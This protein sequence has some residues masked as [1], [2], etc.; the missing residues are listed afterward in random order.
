MRRGAI[1]GVKGRV[2]IQGLRLVSQASSGGGRAGAGGRGAGAAD[3]VGPASFRQLSDQASKYL[4]EAAKQQ[5]RRQGGAMEARGGEVGEGERLRKNL[6]E[7]F[8]DDVARGGPLAELRDAETVLC[9]VEKLKTGECSGMA[10]APPQQQ[11]RAVDGDEARGL[12]TRHDYLSVPSGQ[13]P[14]VP[15][16]SSLAGD[17]AS[18]IGSFF[19]RGGLSN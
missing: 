8:R 2:P 19:T 4:G 3:H 14:Q 12:A 7:G 17:L 18:S 11:P 5:E 15:T 10:A 6:K 16:V 9:T 1:A 13:V